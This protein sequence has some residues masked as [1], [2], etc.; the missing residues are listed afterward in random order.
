MSWTTTFGTP[1]A[2]PCY[3]L[4]LPCGLPLWYSP[5]LLSPVITLGYPEP[6]YKLILP[7]LLKL[8]NNPPPHPLVLLGARN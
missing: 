1:P 8:E 6:G 4:G 2:L 3:T 5:S 7:F